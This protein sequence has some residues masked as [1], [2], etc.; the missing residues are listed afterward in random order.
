[1]PSLR[2]LFATALLAAWSPPAAAMRAE[3][4]PHEPLSLAALARIA[5]NPLAKVYS[6]P[7][8]NN[9][10]FGVGPRKQAENILNIQP[11]LPF[12]IND[13][14]N[15]ITRTV[16]PVTSQPGLMPG[17]GSSFG[18]GATQGSFFLSPARQTAGIG[19]GAGVLVQAPSVTDPAL[20][21]RVWGA[22]PSGI[23]LA[24]RG[25]WVVGTLLNNVWSFGGGPQDA[26]NTFTFQPLINYNFAHS[27][28]TYLSTQPLITADWLAPPGQRWTVPVGLA[29]G[30]V[31]RVSGQP[32][33]ANLGAY[34]NVIRPDDAPAWQIRFQL[35]FLFAR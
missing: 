3:G 9:T 10:N 23:A 30:Q 7:F 24:M 29:L 32:M 13:D 21:S 34:Y 27:P 19:W 5:Q 8:Q 25:P 11:L 4:N 26:Y 18:L 15:L 2:I 1:M 22:G 16:F 6:L 12:G 20:G 33:N 28:G 17:Q 35:V 31:F 14:W